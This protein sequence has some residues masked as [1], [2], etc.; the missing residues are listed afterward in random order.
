MAFSSS[1][2]A[3][4]ANYTTRLTRARSPSR[5]G[6]EMS[7]WN[8]RRDRE[9]RPQDTQRTGPWL[10]LVVVE[11]VDRGVRLSVV[12]PDVEI[13]RGDETSAR[14][15]RVWLRDRSVSQR[16]ARLRLEKDG[17]SLEH[18][19]TASNPTLLNGE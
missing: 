14:D 10:A 3:A 15:E 9:S 2:Q 5:L 12:R 17:W 1:A 11:G 13:G 4:D 18:L 19:A 16:Q 7:W 8:R 6:R